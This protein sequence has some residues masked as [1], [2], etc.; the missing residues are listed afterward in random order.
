MKKVLTACGAAVKITTIA[1]WRSIMPVASG[2]YYYAFQSVRGDCPPVVLIHGAGGTH[3]SWPAEIRRLNGFCSYAPDLPGHGKSSAMDGQQTI[4]GYRQG[5]LTWLAALGLP[6]A[7]FV[8]HSMGGA[9]VLDLAIH[10]PEH[11][12]GLGLVS[13]GPRLA[14]NSQIMEYAARPATGHKAVDALV[15]LSFSAHTA[16]QLAVL[17]GQGL[18]ETR[19]SVLHGDLLAC[20]GF[21][22]TE[23][24]GAV[25]A[26]TLVICGAEDR[27]TPV[28]HS[29]FLAGAIASAR[30]EVV[31]RAGHMVMLEHPQAVAE[32][33]K[34][35]ISA[36]PFW[37][38][39][40]V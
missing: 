14:V 30:L 33:L 27:I 7:V 9:I 3:L 24:V 11:V 20:Q 23:Q 39:K 34:A 6:R 13:S 35:F 15:E 5:V 18:N 28:R 4:A 17:A 37:P 32:A 36:I 31:P 25:R 22:V 16:P 12:L 29:Q 8:G 26:P 10:H 19:P 40:D 21:D 2:I 38:G 1:L